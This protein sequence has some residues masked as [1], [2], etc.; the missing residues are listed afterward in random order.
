MR[1]KG[2]GF[3][4][5]RKAFR[6]KHSRART[7][8][9]ATQKPAYLPPFHVAHHRDRHASHGPVFNGL[10]KIVGAG[11]ECIHSLCGQRAWHRLQEKE[12]RWGE[13][14]ATPSPSPLPP[15]YV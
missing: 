14:A 7:P 13:L 6:R 10:I 9:N 11:H 5:G 2:E 3:R 4:P 12:G 15:T 1:I 8:Q